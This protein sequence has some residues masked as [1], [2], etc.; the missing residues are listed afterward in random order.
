[1]NPG[2]GNY[3]LLRLA[4]SKDQYNSVSLIPFVVPTNPGATST[5]SLNA[6]ASK[7]IKEKEVHDMVLHYVTLIMSHSLVFK[8]AI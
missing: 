1:M 4:V 3:D 2:D 8:S 7:L 5:Y 6:T